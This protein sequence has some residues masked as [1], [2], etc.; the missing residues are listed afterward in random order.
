MRLSS[1]GL[2]QYLAP[3]LAALLAVAF[4]GETFSPMRAL[5]LFF[6]WTGIAVFSIDS[7]RAELGVTRWSRPAPPPEPSAAPRE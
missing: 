4:Y 7:L 5:S 6:I 2:F 1:L 3:S